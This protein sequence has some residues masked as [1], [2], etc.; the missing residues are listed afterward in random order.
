LLLLDDGRVGIVGL[1][2]STFLGAGLRDRLAVLLESLDRRNTEAAM[3]A[4]RDLLEIPAETTF[5]VGGRALIARQLEPIDSTSRDIEDSMRR[6]LQDPLQ[7]AVSIGLELP[8]L[9]VECVRTLATISETLRRLAP[10]FASWS[11]LAGYLKLR[12]FRRADPA[13]VFARARTEVTQYARLLQ[14]LPALMGRFDDSLRTAER[15]AVTTSRSIVRWLGW[16]FEVVGLGLVG[17]SWYRHRHPEVLTWVPWWILLC[18]G[19][20]V[21]FTAGLPSVRNAAREPAP[22]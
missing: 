13:A 21:I 2:I 14:G 7:F 9:P 17:L 6:A 4:L 5:D 15:G 1:R 16:I 11:R 20:V 8:V 22:A 12:R 19:F 10:G 3:A 18:A